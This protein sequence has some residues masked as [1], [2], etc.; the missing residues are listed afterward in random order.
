MNEP[1]DAHYCIYQQTERR[2]VVP[3]EFSFTAFLAVFLFLRFSLCVCVCV[4]VS[5]LSC[6]IRAFAYQPITP[7]RVVRSSRRERHIPPTCT[8]AP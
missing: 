6:H 2:S 5:P 8:W 7:R 1:N 3:E 4:C